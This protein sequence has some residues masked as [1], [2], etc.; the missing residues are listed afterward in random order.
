MPD[1]IGRPL[2]PF[3]DALTVPPRHV[4]SEPARLTV[5]LRTAMHRFHRD[6][7]PSRVWTYDGHVP[8][9]T[10]ER[11][12]RDRLEGATIRVVALV[13]REDEDPGRPP[14]LT[15]RE[16]AEEPDATGPV[17]TLVETGAG[18]EE[19]VTH[20][21]TVATRFEDTVGFPHPRA[22]G[23]RHDASLRGHARR[24]DGVQGQ[25]DG[26]ILPTPG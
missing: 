9:P 4:F 24:A 5:R 15:M 3:V 20:W 22:R 7:P 1:R 19:R 11:I 26:L 12:D 13:E 2:T 14:M 8:G 23:P 25:L 17:I 21:R 16:L 6:L 18:A 10:I